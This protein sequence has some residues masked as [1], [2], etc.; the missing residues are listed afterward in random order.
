MHKYLQIYGHTGSWKLIKIYN[1]Q[2][3]IFNVKYALF[4]L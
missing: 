4:V 2:M 1:V 3:V